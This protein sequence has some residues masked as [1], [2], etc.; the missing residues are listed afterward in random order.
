MPRL[1][2]TVST[3]LAAAL[4]ACDGGASAN[5]SAQIDPA[6]SVLKGEVR[7]YFSNEVISGVTVSVTGSA[8]PLIAKTDNNGRFELRNVPP[9]SR[10]ALQVHAATGYLDTLNPVFITNGQFVTAYLIGLASA[11]KQYTAV[12]VTMQSSSSMVMVELLKGDGTPRDRVPLANITLQPPAPS[13]RGPYFLGQEGLSP[14]ALQ[15]VTVQ[16]RA[17]FALVNV[18]VGTYTMSIQYPPDLDAVPGS[19]PALI[20]S[21][22]FTTVPNQAV[23]VRVNDPAATQPAVP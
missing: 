13:G 9:G 2:V 20:K 5:R 12:G 21:A 10:V 3:L 23:L 16:G 7:S 14:F 11:R 17:A 4:A 6:R 22:T 15:S 18:P 8:R 19:N 1:L